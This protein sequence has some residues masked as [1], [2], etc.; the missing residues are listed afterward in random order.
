M[1]WSSNG[2]DPDAHLRVLVASLCHRT[3]ETLTVEVLTGTPEVRFV[4]RRG[5]EIIAQAANRVRDL[6]A[7]ETAARL[8]RWQARRYA[9]AGG[10]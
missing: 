7:R 1:S 8:W 4:V 10:R 9:A 6:A 3:Q 2:Y 5:P